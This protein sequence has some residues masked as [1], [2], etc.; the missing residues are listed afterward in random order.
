[1]S[2]QP[3]VVERLLVEEAAAI[4][5]AAEDVERRRPRYAVIAARGSSDN[6]A[7]Y[8]QHLM[9]RFWGMPVALATPS[10]H[11]LYEAPLRY[12]DALVVGI[13]QSGA[14]PDVAGVV[15]EATAQGAL[16]IA[17]TNAPDSPLARA[18]QHVIGLQTGEERSV[19]ATKTYTASLAAVAG[20]V[21]GTEALLRVPD[22]MARQLEHDVPAEA[23]A[24][25]QRLA[26]IGRGANY[27]TAFEA[28]LKLSELTGAVAAPWSSAD[29]LHGPIAIVDA[30]FPILAF[31]PSG[32]TLAGM[33]ELLTV[34]Q[35]RGAELTVVSD[36]PLAGRIPLEPV[37]EWL[38]PLVAV[39]PAQLIAVGAAEHLGRDVDRPTG[40]QKVTRTS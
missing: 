23:A 32:P 1:M 24:A 12:D 8:A 18:A 26:V 20:L 40:L 9:G 14:S 36:A 15:S 2:E 38:S 11:T 31:A 10:L 4:A 39:I 16:T 17:I 28:A 29:F 3:E 21:S 30:G 13:S 35:E 33:R 22:A 5:A 34:A 19:A 37:P 27:G 25:W 6:A 7:R